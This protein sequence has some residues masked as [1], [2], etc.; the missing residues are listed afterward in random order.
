VLAHLLLLLLLLL[1]VVVVMVW[2]LCCCRQAADGQ[3]SAESA[4]AKRLSLCPVHHHLHCLQAVHLTMSPAAYHPAA[5]L[6]CA[7]LIHQHAGCWRAPCC[8]LQ[9]QQHL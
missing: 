1:A 2:S 4:A 6:P 5:L 9:Y 7:A 3:T 8:L